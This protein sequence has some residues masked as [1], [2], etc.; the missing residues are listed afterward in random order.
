MMRLLLQTVLAP[1][2]AVCLAHCLAVCLAL[3]LGLTRAQASEDAPLRTMHNADEARDWEGVGRIDMAGVGF[4]T[5]ALISP[6]HV[7]TAAHCLFDRRTGQAIPLERISFQAGLREGRAVAHREAR[8]T[9]VHRDYDFSTSDSMTRVAADIALIELDRPIR[10]SVIRPF[11]RFHQPK[12]GDEV[13]VVSYARERENAPT[14]QEKCHML[15]REN[16]V[17]VYSCAVDFGASGSP[18]FVMSDARPKIAS[19]ISAMAQWQEQDVALGAAL[20]KPL[21]ELL[22]QLAQTDPVFRAVPVR[23]ERADGSWVSISEQ[24][25]RNRA[26]VR[27]VILPQV[28]D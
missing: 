7:L 23:P 28:G 14:M 9:I 22:T 17:L 10:E 3:S 13:M 12:A 24:L 18:I 19:V 21:D 4:C 1:R 20:G 5:G 8:R 6:R 2:S 11:E 25:G 26:T 27:N 16:Q 15:A